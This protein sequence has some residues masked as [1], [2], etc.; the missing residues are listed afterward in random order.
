MGE[1]QAYEYQIIFHLDGQR[2]ETN[3]VLTWQDHETVAEVFDLLGIKEYAILRA[4]KR[5]L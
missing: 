3:A 5:A 2:L 1:Q 4:D